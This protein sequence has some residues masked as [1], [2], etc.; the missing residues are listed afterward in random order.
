MTEAKK[1]PAKKAP[2]KAA[3]KAASNCMCKADL[4]SLVTALIVSRGSMN[5]VAAMETAKYIVETA[6]ESA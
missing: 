3:A 2:V 6:H 4:V 5:T 1:A